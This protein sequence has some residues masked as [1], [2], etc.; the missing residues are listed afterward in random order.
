MNIFIGSI[1]KT[2]GF[3]GALVINTEN[4]INIELIENCINKKGFVFI[5]I[6]EIQVPFF[7]TEKTKI[8]NN[9]SILIFLDDIFDNNQAKK[10]INSKIFVENDCFTENSKPKLHINNNL[11]GFSVT[12]KNLGHIGYIFDFINIPANPLLVVKKNNKE[13]LIPVNNNFIIEINDKTKELKI[14]LPEGLVDIND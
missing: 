10:Y 5:N 12:D 4:Q 6:D 11:I 13:I 8:L 2:H 7:I 3:D 14:E 9:K 1:V